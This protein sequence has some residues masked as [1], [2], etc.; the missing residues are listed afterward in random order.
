MR[1]D[2]QEAISLRRAGSS[3]RQI[4]DALKIPL[5]TLSDW[6][7]EEDWSSVM[8][9]KLTSSAQVQHTARIVELNRT[10]GENLELAYAE[11]REEAREDLLKYQ[12]NPLFIA[13]LMLYWG[14]GDKIS[15]AAVRLTN[16]DPELIA[17]Y[18]QFLE[19]V[20]RIPVEKI[21]A[22]VLVYP[23]LDERVCREYW[24]KNSGVGLDRFT[25]SIVIEGRHKTRR[26]EHGVCT[27]TVSSTYLKVK[28]V[29]WMKLLPKELMKRE[30]YENIKAEADIV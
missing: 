13:G 26:L 6:F 20:C 5:S 23:D 19:R 3:Y 17:L 29:E 28:M 22:S 15:K 10:R 1:K 9:A 8:R 24:A 30:Y 18:V 27:I 7:A 11:A 16:T 14:E 21:R 2:K 4:R 25:K 12:Y